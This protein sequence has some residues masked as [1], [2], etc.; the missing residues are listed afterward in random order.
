MRTRRQLSDDIDR[1]RATRSIYVEALCEAERRA[2]HLTNTGVQTTVDELK[3]RVDQISTEFHAAVKE[4]N[5]LTNGVTH[6]P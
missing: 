4:W 6:S 3:K 1:L 5:D 2:R